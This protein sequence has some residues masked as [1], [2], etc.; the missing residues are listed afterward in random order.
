MQAAGRPPRGVTRP[1]LQQLFCVCGGE[2]SQ[3]Q[4]H[5][6]LWRQ[7]GGLSLR[8]VLLPCLRQFSTATLLQSL[9]SRKS[10]PLP[11]LLHLLV[12]LWQ[13]VN[14]LQGFV[15]HEPPR[16]GPRQHLVR[17][18]DHHN[19]ALPRARRGGAPRQ[20]SVQEVVCQQGVG[21]REGDDDADVVLQSLG[22]GKAVQEPA[23]W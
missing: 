11:L 12:W 23:G 6:P 10:P 14:H 13:P 8:R 5:Q 19:E 7:R 15:P 16:H 1:L 4:Q 9:S 18:V 20:V 22:Q 21:L 2:G 17:V 3:R